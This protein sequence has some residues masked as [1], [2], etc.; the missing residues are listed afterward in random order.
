MIWLALVLLLVVLIRRTVLPPANFPKS[1]PTIP[2]YVSFLP[3]VTGWDQTQVFER[4]L[5]TPF[6]THGAVKLYFAGRWNVVFA[7]PSYVL[8]MWKHVD[9]FTKSGNQEKIPYSVLA[10]Y[11]GDNVISAHGQMWKQY[12]YLVAPA[13][14]HPDLSLIAQNTAEAVAK[15]DREPLGQLLQKLAL[16]N[17]TTLVLGADI[18]VDYWLPQING[19][20]RVIFKPIYMAFAWLDLIVPS[21]WLAKR[22]IARFRHSFCQALVDNC[23]VGGAT[24]KLNQAYELG[25]LN[26]KQF[27]DNVIILMV[28]G[29]ENPLLFMLSLLFVIAKYGL[30]PQIRANPELLDPV[31][32]ETLRLYPPLGQIVNR[33]TSM[34][35]E[36][37]GIR[38]PQG[39]YVG[40]HNYA[41]GRDPHTWRNPDQFDPYRWGNTP[42]ET[43]ANFELA[44]RMAHLPAFHGRKRACLGQK[45]ALYQCKELVMAVI[46]QYDLQLA[47]EWQ[48]RWTA[49]G[50]ICPVNLNLKF[51]KV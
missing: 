26:Q 22:R 49:A 44:K 43:K 34:P 27:E 6:A 33:K 1:I 7:R 24:N 41:T 12:R 5:K 40:Y 31:M 39:T 36:V 32:Y 2:F 45:F 50:P 17:V 30:A 42:A 8:T 37:D 14:Q 46:N 10:H 3:L 18:D 23:R 29:H 19:I 38:I 35:L 51:N 28:A 20:K 48:E 11:T 15:I 47:D 16:A 4:Y 13:I 21:R 9:K 25:D